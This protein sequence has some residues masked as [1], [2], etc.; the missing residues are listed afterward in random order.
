M[1]DEPISLVAYDPA[2]PERFQREVRLAAALQHP[3]VVPL[4]AAGEA[5]GIL[6]Y[7]MPFI[8]GES[9][10]ARIDREGALPIPEAARILRDV[11]AALAYAHAH[12]VVHRDI[13]PDNVLITHHHAVVTD[14]GIAKALSAAGNSGTLTATGIALGTPAYMAPEQAV[15]DSHVDQRADIYSLGALGYEMIAGEPPFRGPSA[16]A[17]IAAHLS[18]TPTPL[19]E[20]R[21][22]VPAALAAL[23]ARCL[24]K[25]P[26]DRVQSAEELLVELESGAKAPSP[27][28][29]V[30]LLQASKVEMVIDALPRLPPPVTAASPSEAPPTSCARRSPVS[31]RHNQQVKTI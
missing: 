5:D 25:N 4:L 17:L 3:H 30:A 12:G 14:F 9:L 19:A 28:L 18:R 26:A 10:R 29:R 21:S 23:L 16:Q 22:T 15:G 20:L 2:W 13:K 11:A 31:A 8:E 1:R 6:Y 7:S 24:E 27:P